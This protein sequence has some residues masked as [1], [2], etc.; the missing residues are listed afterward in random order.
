MLTYYNPGTRFTIKY[1]DIIYVL[2]GYTTNN[3][4]VYYQDGI[5][6]K[7]NLNISSPE[8]ISSII[9]YPTFDQKTKNFKY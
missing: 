3:D 8:V 5:D 9:S 6:V 1:S 7:N 4:L 2:I